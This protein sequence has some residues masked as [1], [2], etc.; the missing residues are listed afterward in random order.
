MDWQTEGFK[1]AMRAISRMSEDD[2]ELT[3]LDGAT[4]ESV[5]KIVWKG[6]RRTVTMVTESARTVFDGFI[7]EQLETVKAYKDGEI[8]LDK[9]YEVEQEAD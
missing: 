8:I 9:I 6:K 1:F 7:D 2:K 3:G 4:A 5:T